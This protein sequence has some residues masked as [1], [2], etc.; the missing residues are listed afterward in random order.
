MGSR[1][2]TLSLIVSYEADLMSGV[3]FTKFSLLT[4]ASPLFFIGTGEIAFAH[5]GHD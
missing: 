1:T 3:T 2:K 5:L 4:L